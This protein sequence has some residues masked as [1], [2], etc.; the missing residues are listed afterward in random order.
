M[1][2]VLYPEYLQDFFVTSDALSV[3]RNTVCGFATGRGNPLKILALIGGE[4]W[5][6]RS[7]RCHQKVMFFFSANILLPR[8]YCKALLIES[9]GTNIEEQQKYCIFCIPRGISGDSLEG[10][11]WLSLEAATW[12]RP[13][14]WH[15]CCQCRPL[16]RPG[17][18]AGWALQAGHAVLGKGEEVYDKPRNTVIIVCW[19][20]VQWFLVNLKC[21]HQRQWA[22]GRGS[23]GGRC[24]FRTTC[25]K[26][27]LG[28]L[29][30]QILGFRERHQKGFVDLL[31][32]TE[33][34]F[35]QESSCHWHQ[36]NHVLWFVS[37]TWREKKKQKLLFKSTLLGG[38]HWIGV[39]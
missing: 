10:H 35:W 30:K 28:R 16:P 5:P 19:C 32:E 7:G 9:G 36:T 23:V 26:W 6:E 1:S 38:S 22:V 39:E 25:T 14:Q 18:T 20:S 3:A 37:E 4:R 24:F 13:W 29:L 27:I 17:S 33:M 12:W 21:W 11:L 15:C 31:S 34:N 2:L 8:E